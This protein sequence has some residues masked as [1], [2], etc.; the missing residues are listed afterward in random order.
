[1]VS[2]KQHCI[3]EKRKLT[4]IARYREG[5]FPIDKFSKFI[6]AAEFDRGLKEMHEGG[7]IKPIMI[8]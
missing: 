6:P 7:T 3:P 1:M 8:W 2:S 4:L 5:K